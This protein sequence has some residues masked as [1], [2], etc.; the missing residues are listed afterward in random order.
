MTSEENNQAELEQ[1]EQ[2]EL[3]RIAKLSFAGQVW[4]KLS[5]I[6][7]NELTEEKGKFTYLSWMGAWSSLMELYPESDYEMLENEYFPDETMSVGMRVTIKEGVNS[8]SR[9]M[10]LQ[11][12]NFSNKA[13]PNPTAHDINN[14]RMRCLTKA[15]AMHGL[16]YYL[17]L[18]GHDLPLKEEEKVTAKPKKIGQPRKPHDDFLADVK[19]AMDN[20]TTIG[21]LEVQFNG[22]LKHFKQFKADEHIKQLIEHKDKIKATFEL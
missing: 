14:S 19:E 4:A 1:Q 3:E 16:G 20:V 5:I 15:A 21:A 18:K 7:I 22:A 9:D 12:L 17:Y 8:I 2:E 10:W 13:I 6:N 11:V